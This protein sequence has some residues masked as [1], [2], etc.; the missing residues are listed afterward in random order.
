MTEA[1]LKADIA[2]ITNDELIELAEKEN[3]QL[4]ATGGQSLHMT[5]PPSAKDSDMILGEIISRYKKLF[6]LTIPALKKEL[7]DTERERDLYDEGSRAYAELDF[8]MMG[9]LY[10]LHRISEATGHDINPYEK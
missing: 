1:Q 7:I 5:V 6:T 3:S 4:H 9:I 10:S 2:A 8:K